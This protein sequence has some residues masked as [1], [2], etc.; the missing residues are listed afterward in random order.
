MTV[1][2]CGFCNSVIGEK[3]A[4]R[5]VRE[6]EL[7]ENTLRAKLDAVRELHHPFGIYD[8]CGHN[9]EY[10]DGGNLREGV[11]EVKEVGLTCEEGL[12]YWVCRHCCTDRG[13]QTEHCTIYHYHG[14]NEPAC[15]TL[16]ILDGGGD[17]E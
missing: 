1:H 7:A 11:I 13:W 5:L 2:H 10:L 14:K 9:H 6:T 17:V 8:E 4:D 3:E 12:E 15:Q 16:R